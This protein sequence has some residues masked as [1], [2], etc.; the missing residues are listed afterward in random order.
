VGL[1]VVPVSVG[2]A[3]HPAR[4]SRTDAALACAGVVAVGNGQ[5]SVGQYFSVNTVSINVTAL[6]FDKPAT[7]TGTARQLRL[8]TRPPS[9]AGTVLGSAF[10]TSETSTGIQTATL[11][12]SVTLAPG[13]Y[14]LAMDA[15]NTGY[16]GDSNWLGETSGDTYVVAASGA[17]AN[18]L[19]NYP[20]I[21]GYSG[22]DYALRTVYEWSS[23][24]HAAATATPGVATTYQTVLM[25]AAGEG[26]N[27]PQYI[28][29]LIVDAAVTA[30]A[31]P[32][33]FVSYGRHHTVNVTERVVYQDTAGRYYNSVQLQSLD[34][35][36]EA[37]G[38]FTQ[39]TIPLSPLGQAVSLRVSVSAAGAT[40]AQTGPM[41][42]LAGATY[43]SVYRFPLNLTGVAWHDPSSST[44][45]GPSTAL[46]GQEWVCSRW[47]ITN[48]AG[49]GATATPAPQAGN[50]TPIPAAAT[51]TPAPTVTQENN[52]DVS[53]S[54]NRQTDTQAGWFGR[55]SAQLGEVTQSITNIPGNTVRAVETAV[56]APPAGYSETKTAGM[57][58]A[59]DAKFEPIREG[60]TALTAV[61]DGMVEADC[62][63][64]GGVV[65]SLPMFGGSWSLTLF[66]GPFM[67][68]FYCPVVRP[69]IALAVNV[70]VVFF[71]MFSLM[72]IFRRLG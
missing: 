44:C 36:I 20:S 27:Y 28:E 72:A 41:P 11:S 4:Y 61:V 54:I 12:A 1:V 68:G 2:L 8:Y 30:W 13:N 45:Y 67:T 34:Q 51:A 49:A 23:E 60:Q 37:T 29:A 22:S 48:G 35:V 7:M 10:T 25:Q 64:F 47:V 21:T 15:D 65:V 14:A 16:C 42:G 3:A 70:A 40:V 9:G 33:T 26:A 66:S 52:P 39:E 71:S 38:A 24:A 58:A 56:G 55:I 46:V 53:G 43:V 17:Y 19:N 59:V 69:L 18:G 32:Q 31:N 63:T 57:H 5:Y 50:P 62:D 6:Q